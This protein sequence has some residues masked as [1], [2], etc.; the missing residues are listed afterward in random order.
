[1]I[2]KYQRLKKIVSVKLEA[3]KD[4]SIEKS[5][6][7]EPTLGIYQSKQKS[8]ETDLV[9]PNYSLYATDI[10]NKYPETHQEE[11]EPEV[12]EDEDIKHVPPIRYY[13]DSDL[14]D[15]VDIND[16]S[17]MNF[18]LKTTIGL[19][20]TYKT[21]K[22]EDDLMPVYTVGVFDDRKIKIKKEIKQL[23]K[24]I[25]PAFNKLFMP[26]KE[27]LNLC[28]KYL[29]L[30]FYLN[31]YNLNDKLTAVYIEE[32]IKNRSND[33]SFNFSEY[34]MIDF[35]SL[36]DALLGQENNESNYKNK[37][38]G[39]FVIKDPFDLM[40]LKLAPLKKGILD[41]SFKLRDLHAGCLKKGDSQARDWI[42]CLLI[43]AMTDEYYSRN[44]GMTENLI[45][46]L[47][48]DEWYFLFS[49]KYLRFTT[50]IN[51]FRKNL[52]KRFLSLYLKTREKYSI[53]HKIL[54]ETAIKGISHCI[55]KGEMGY[56]L[57]PK[58][59]LVFILMLNSKIQVP[60]RIPE[61]KN[62]LSK[63]Q[64]KELN[65]MIVPEITN[66]SQIIKLFESLFTV[67]YEQKLL[68]YLTK[69]ILKIAEPKE[70]ERTLKKLI[71]NS[72][73][74]SSNKKSR[75]NSFINNVFYMVSLCQLQQDWLSK[76]TFLIIIN[77]LLSFGPSK[78]YLD[79]AGFFSCR[80]QETSRSNVREI[81]F[82]F[83]TMINTDIS[84]ING[85][86]L[87]QIKKNYDKNTFAVEQSKWIDNN[88][89]KKTHYLRSFLRNVQCLANKGALDPVRFIECFMVEFNTHFYI[90]ILSI[91]AKEKVGGKLFDKLNSTLSDFDERYKT[92]SY[93]NPK[94]IINAFQDLNDWQTAVEMINLCHILLNKKL[95]TSVFPNQNKPS[96]CSDLLEGIFK[97]K[98][99]RN[100]MDLKS[101]DKTA[102]FK[103]KEHMTAF[104]AGLSGI[105]Q[106]VKPKQ[107]IARQ[108][109]KI[110]QNLN[111][112]I[113]FMIANNLSSACNKLQKISLR[114]GTK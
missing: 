56:I 28:N 50:Q 77:Q 43:T 68:L 67:E 92:S 86:Y 37:K 60:V 22:Q 100:L 113:T 96:A 72:F 87:K 83:K 16:L 103:Q 52:I 93:F 2:T 84:K 18:S 36:H 85:N 73:F 95:F 3:D 98:S 20:A 107:F 51:N 31:N 89:V 9:I 4:I 48:P 114:L 90:V 65:D 29:I 35:T 24:M 112:T 108:K 17:F 74:S 59:P 88:L 27:F 78:N 82:F 34:N 30:S 94:N 97:I 69:T 19:G 14:V 39:C 91:L 62:P 44:Q 13:I 26:D 10:F 15:S 76:E 61:R 25:L 80:Y 101:Q 12:K 47:Q 70:V 42:I 57:D 110:Q 11:I 46:S 5:P 105:F 55:A 1:M 38:L 53:Q 75:L 64:E 21:D 99:F 41:K 33:F 7:Q 32:Y 49:N 54:K 109:E 8:Y 79:H 106:I 104:I 71:K 45:L 6:K 63:K 66:K 102:V 58:E 40:L 23:R 111:D 81:N